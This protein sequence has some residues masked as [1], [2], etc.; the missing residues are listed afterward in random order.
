MIIGKDDCFR[1]NFSR[2][3]LARSIA[4]RCLERVTEIVIWTSGLGDKHERKRWICFV[5]SK[6]SKSCKK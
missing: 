4:R 3:I 5:F 2:A 1:T 6:T